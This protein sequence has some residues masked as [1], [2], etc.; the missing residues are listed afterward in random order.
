[1]YVFYGMES[2]FGEHRAVERERVYLDTG[3]GYIWKGVKH[4]FIPLA[5]VCLQYTCT[6]LGVG[7]KVGCVVL[8]HLPFCPGLGLPHSQEGLHCSLIQ[9]AQLHHIEFI[10]S[11]QELSKASRSDFKSRILNS[12]VSN[13]ES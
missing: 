10:F 8:V 2:S 4:L 11:Q 7:G 9:L 13:A 1:M 3:R 12:T 6:E 5:C